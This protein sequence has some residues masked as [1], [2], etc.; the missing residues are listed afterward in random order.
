M[1]CLTPRKIFGYKLPD[2]ERI[3]NGHTSLVYLCDDPTVLEVFT[4]EVMKMDWWMYGLK[5]ITDY[6]DV[7]TAYY[8][9]MDVS[10]GGWQQAKYRQYKLPVY[11]CIVQRLEMP[12]FEQRR[13]IK[14]ARNT[15]SDIRIKWATRGMRS[16][17]A[18]NLWELWDA[19]ENLGDEYPELSE[20]AKFVTNYDAGRINPDF[21]P[22]DW[23]ILN[24]EVV[25]IDPYHHEDIHKALRLRK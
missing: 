10:I 12:N 18:D 9:G 22:G 16:F 24:G 8:G 11:R 14:R 21:G 23:A 6:E 20:P 13:Q 1:M 4:I 25:C 17:G 2:R 19:I 7:A 15:Y 3:G 5:I